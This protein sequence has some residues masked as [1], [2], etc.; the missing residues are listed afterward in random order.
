MGWMRRILGRSRAGRRQ[1]GIEPPAQDEPGGPHVRDPIP[2][3][4]SGLADWPES[5][6]PPSKRTGLFWTGFEDAAG[7]IETHHIVFQQGRNLHDLR[8]LIADLEA[9]KQPELTGLREL[10]IDMCYLIN[11]LGQLRAGYGSLREELISVREKVRR[12]LG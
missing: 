5:A 4:E 12:A 2:R 9:G 1:Y 7:F 10:L 3:R 8:V 11:A 6:S